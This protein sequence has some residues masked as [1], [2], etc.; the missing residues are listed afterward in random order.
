MQ[1]LLKYTVNDLLYIKDR[2]GVYSHISEHGIVF[3]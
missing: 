1:A 2:Y 3:A